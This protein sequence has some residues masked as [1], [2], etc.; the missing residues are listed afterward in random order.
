MDSNEFERPMLKKSVRWVI[1]ITFWIMCVHVGQSSGIISPSGKYISVDLQ[2]S[3]VEYACISPVY[4]IGKMTGAFI[5]PFV[6]T[7]VNRKFLIVSACLLHGCINIFFYFT[8]NAYLMLSLRCVAG[9]CYGWTTIYN[10]VWITQL[11]I[12]KYKKVWKYMQSICSPTG[13]AS[14][15]FIDL[16]FGWPNVSF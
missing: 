2:I 12:E 16:I 1:F 14:G 15:F 4:S 8:S 7:T 11:G 13:R 9:I 10:G 5:F 6:F 3:D